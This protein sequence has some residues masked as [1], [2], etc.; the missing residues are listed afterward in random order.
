MIG[1]IVTVFWNVV[2]EEPP[3][4]INEQ[5]VNKVF[6]KGSLVLHPDKGGDLL[7]FQNFSS[8]RNMI[9]DFIR[10]AGRSY[11]TPISTMWKCIGCVLLDWCRTSAATKATVRN[12]CLDFDNLLAAMLWNSHGFNFK[13]ETGIKAL[14]HHGAIK[15]P[16]NSD[17]SR[18]CYAFRIDGEMYVDP[19]NHTYATCMTLLMYVGLLPTTKCHIMQC[20]NA[21]LG[22]YIECLLG[23]QFVAIPHREAWAY[24][25]NKIIT[26]ISKLVCTIAQFSIPC[27]DCP[28]NGGLPPN[29]VLSGNTLLKHLGVPLEEVLVFWGKCTKVKKVTDA[30]AVRSSDSYSGSTQ[31]SSSPPPPPVEWHETFSVEYNAHYYWNE[32]TREVTWKRPTVPY[33]HANGVNG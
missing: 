11:E 24:R 22:D 12:V 25:V 17:D 33:K 1:L 27:K 4:S 14:S 8:N 26:L 6:R 16:V 10:K 3:A 13:G 7:I 32:Q 29:M 28:W 9:I 15:L 20:N 2:G 21:K 30:L 18:K 23:T 5:L 19:G 31:T